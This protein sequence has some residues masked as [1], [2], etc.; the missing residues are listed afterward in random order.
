MLTRVTVINIVTDTTSS[1][2]GWLIG[3][4]KVEDTKG[5]EPPKKTKRRHISRFDSKQLL[6]TELAN[7]FYLVVFI[8]VNLLFKRLISLFLKSSNVDENMI[9]TRK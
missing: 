8:I 4:K 9:S 6:K 1:L 5:S 3:G 7:C 2:G